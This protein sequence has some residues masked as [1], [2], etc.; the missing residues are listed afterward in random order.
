LES[1]LD[2]ASH[3][4]NRV[5]RRAIKSNAK[6]DIL[7]SKPTKS[8]QASKPFLATSTMTSVFNKQ[9]TNVKSQ[10]EAFE[11]AVSAEFEFEKPDD[12]QQDLLEGV[13]KCLHLK[14]VASNANRFKFCDLDESNEV[15]AIL[16]R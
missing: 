2:R 8:V 13:A 7:T 10:A 14:L 9:A 4:K 15:A 16:S 6:C 1:F 12:I 11:K 3:N 5:E